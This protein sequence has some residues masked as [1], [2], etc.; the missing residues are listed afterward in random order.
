MISELTPFFDSSRLI[1]GTSRYPSLHTMQSA[2]QQSGTQIITVAIRRQMPHAAQGNAFWDSLRQLP[3]KILPNTAGCH[4]AKD[5]VYTAE[6]A[7]ELFQTNWIKL[8]VIGDD[9]T[10]Q[11]DPFELSIAAQ[12]LNAKGF[13]V[14]PYCT[15]DLILCQRLADSGCSVLMPLASPIGS[16]Q[17]ILN[18]YALALLRSRFADLHL[19]VDAG[20]GKP[21]HATT[22]MEMGFDAVLLNT[23][24]ARAMD[25]IKMAEAFRDAIIAGRKGFEAGMIIPSNVA[26][27]STSLVDVPF[28]KQKQTENM[29]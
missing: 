18:P 16:G 22:V 28:W 15:D 7:R 23:A 14:M 11:P 20:I 27:P 21:S 1:L 9:Y 4:T 3:C 5:A 24:V 10:L 8:E 12:Q 6:L 29:Q 2:I 13:F 25:P 17:G 26:Q 19:I